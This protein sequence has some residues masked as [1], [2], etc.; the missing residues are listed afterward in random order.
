[1]LLVVTSEKDL[2]VDYLI[3]RLQERNV[4]YCRLNTERFGREYA[5]TLR[6]DPSGVNGTISMR[7]SRD[8]NLRDITAAYF[9]QP[10]AP[11]LIDIE[12]QMLR[13]FAER[14][15]L[16]LLR[17]LWRLIDEEHWLNDPR[18]M[19]L[20]LNKPLQLSLASKLGFRIPNTLITTDERRIRAFAEEHRGELIAKA[21]KHGF[22][23]EGEDT[24]VAF[25]RRIDET[26]FLDIDKYCG[27]PMIYQPEV[28]K[29]S[30]IR[31]T[32]VGNSVFAAEIHSQDN[33]ETEVDWRT[34]EIASASDLRHSV[35]TLPSHL[36]AKCIE[37]TH[38]FGLR[39]SA[40]DLVL[41]DDGAYWFLEM[42]PNGQW[43]WIEH[44]LGLPIRDAIIDEL[45][46]T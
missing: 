18:K 13:M 38:K 2:A 21:V 19:W 30:D 46:Y 33:E 27:I 43:A 6:I 37:L 44:T 20:A 4:E 25:T 39:Y 45:G 8:V 40:I 16:E 24:Y 28:K 10:S 32:V 31:V 36:G 1:M 41:A 17:S 11:D 5:V 22:L 29:S 14:E 7:S 23:N 35:H 12:D 15:V 26:F 3:L 42:N 9:R 34:W